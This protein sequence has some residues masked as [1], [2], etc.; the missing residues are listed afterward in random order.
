MADSSSPDGFCV[1]SPTAI[2]G[3]GFPEESLKEG[4]K[5]NPDLIAV[6]AG[7]TDP[8]P[9][10]LGS[11]KSFT[12]REGVRRDLER[13]I[14]AQQMIGVPLIIGT[15]GGAGARPH[16]DWT[17]DI[18]RDIV[19]HRG[20]PLKVA[21]IHAEIP[22]DVV[23]TSLEQGRINSLPNVPVLH[24][25][26][27]RQTPRIVA[28]MGH[29]PVI[30]ALQA[31]FDIVICGRCYD[32]AVFAALPIIRNHDPAL[33]LHMG[34]ILECAAIAAKPGSGS[35][36]VLGRLFEDHFILE[37]LSPERRFTRN[38]VAAHSLYE[39]S[40]PYHLPGPGGTLDLANVEYE[41]LGD[42]RVKVSGTRLI[43]ASPYTVKLE[44]A[45]PVGFRTVSMAGIRDPNMIENLDDI[46][47]DV[48]E[49]CRQSMNATSVLNF[50]IYGKNGVM[51][52][53]EPVGALPHEIGLVMEVVAR[54]QETAD[55]ECSLV[56]S[57]LLHFGFPGRL[58][59]AGNL[60]FP[61]SP[62]DF[63]AGEVYEFSI[64]HLMEIDSPTSL[65]P[66]EAIELK[67]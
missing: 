48:E 60:A 53:H 13:L 28:Q 26:T 67:P 35:D 7:S 30:D 62:S 49:S 40:D 33:A 24:E 20:S 50:H 19:K 64:Y 44:G 61:Y 4:I 31:G 29:E 41:D 23:E 51:G 45:R 55:G 32:P 38:S 25:E 12:S 36:C 43:P 2:L 46:L 11:G 42:G 16:V 57:T 18:V 27:I 15:A 58:S 63:S 14:E 65:F 37:P 56:R 54:D 10:Y 66:I 59:T 22:H 9:F 1:L 47:K 6:D 17:L 3:Y 21:V 34:K 39:K 8:G 5:R 52:A